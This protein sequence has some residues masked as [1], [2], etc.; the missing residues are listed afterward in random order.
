MELKVSVE[1]AKV[2]LGK[3]NLGSVGRLIVTTAAADVARLGG[4]LGEGVVNRLD[5]HIEVR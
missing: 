5:R 1:E 3:D 2:C 4:R